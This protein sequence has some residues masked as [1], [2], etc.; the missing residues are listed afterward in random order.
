[1]TELKRRA[2]ECE[3]GTLTDSFTKDMI[4]CGTA[5]PTLR[6]RLLRNADLTLAKAIEAG[7]A[8][9]E[10]KRHA[11]ELEKHQVSEVNRVRHD[12]EKSSKTKESHN[13]SHHSDDMIK[14]CKFCSGSHQRGNCPAYGKRCKTCNRKN[15]FA[16]R[17]SQ[18]MVNQVAG[19][20]TSSSSCDEND[21]KFFIDMVQV[22]RNDPLN[23]SQDVTTSTSTQEA[24]TSTSTLFMINDSKSDWSVTLDMNSTDVTFKIDTGAQCNVIPK[25]LLHK[26]S[27]QPKL[28]PATI[29]L[30]AY[31]GNP[32]PVA[33]K[34]IARI[35]HKGQTT[36]ILFIVVD[37]DSIPILGLN[38]CD[39]LNLIKKV[40]Q[41][42]HDVNSDSIQDEFSDCFGEIGCLNKIHHI[43]IR[44]DVKPVVVPVRK[45]PYALKSK[46]K[47]EL[48]RMV[49]LDIIEPVEKPT[50][51]VNALVV[52]SKPNGK[53]RIC[54][55]PRPLNKAIKRQ[56]HGLPTTEEII[57]EMSGACYFSKLDAASGY[58]QIRVDEESSNLLAFGIP[59]GRYRFKRLPFGIHSASEVFQAEIASIIADL[60]GCAHSQDDIIVWGTSKEEHEPG[61]LIGFIDLGDPLTTFANTDEE[62]PIASHALA[63]LVRGLCTNLKH[64][65]AY[66]FTGNVTS[67]QLLPL[68]WKVVGV[69][70]TTVKLWVIAAVNDGASSNRKFFAL[71]AKLGGTLP[72]GRV[73]KTPN[74]FF[75]ARMIYFFADVPHL[76]KTARNC[77]YNSGYGSRSRFVKFI[78]T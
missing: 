34:C 74:L 31:N 59:F 27:P 8:S 21:D 69:L 6:E 37:S 19:Q 29:K 55:D 33:G 52:V 25:S 66:Y 30:S 9:E 38:T 48:Q 43:E 60:P 39:K 46:L 16:S 72:C 22:D 68:F 28:K 40:Y 32:I 70:E 11:K 18:R 23:E 17:C 56:H 14:K 4:V 2:A 7:H 65:V 15:H 54:L 63:F 67:F 42:S 3:L 57:A 51:W 47:E 73:Y 26:M 45:I 76:I 44:D 49:T 62:T 50:E 75:L 1:M 13:R 12:K 20:D 64:V 10:T 5:D 77:L 36:P 71:H 24:N 53:S 58:W 35:K 61:E 41:I 78:I